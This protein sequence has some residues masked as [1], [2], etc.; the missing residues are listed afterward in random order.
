LLRTGQGM[1]SARTWKPQKKRS[2]G[3]GSDDLFT[4]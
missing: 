1:P 2:S 4:A 3:E